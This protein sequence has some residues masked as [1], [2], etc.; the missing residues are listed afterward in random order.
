VD[1]KIL[2]PSSRAARTPF[3]ACAVHTLRS[4]PL[5]GSRS[6]SLRS[7]PSCRCRPPEPM[8]RTEVP[9][10]ELVCDADAR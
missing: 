1:P 5:V 8:V 9:T 10:S 6:A 3:P 2:A 4:I 7:L